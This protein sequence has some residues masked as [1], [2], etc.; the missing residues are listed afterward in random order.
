MIIRY[1]DHQGSGSW[2]FLGSSVVDLHGA[3]H[4]AAALTC[5]N[6]NP[7]GLVDL[8]SRDYLPTPKAQTGSL[9]SEVYTK[10][11]N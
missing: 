5:H 8:S 1:L 4:K 6:L 10:V 9:Q 11:L 2:V 7:N 3:S